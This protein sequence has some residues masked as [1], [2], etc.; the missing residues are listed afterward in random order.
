[1]RELALFSLEKRLRREL[2]SLYNHVKGGCKQVGVGLFFQAESDRTRCLHCTRGCFVWMPMASWLVSD[3]VWPGLRKFFV[4]ALYMYDT[5][6]APPVLCPIL[7]PSLQDT[8]VLEHVQQKA[9]R[10]VKGLE[11]RNNFL[12]DKHWNRLTNEV[13]ESPLLQ[14]VKK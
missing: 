8:E 10:L 2:I 6:A 14:L 3:L 13:V 4:W 5:D 1:M 12:V 7:G 9:R 11:N